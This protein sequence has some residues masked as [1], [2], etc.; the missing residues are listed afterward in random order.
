MMEGLR[1]YRESEALKNADI[2][3]PRDNRHDEYPFNLHFR[4]LRIGTTVKYPGPL[5]GVLDVATA[6]KAGTPLAHI[7]PRRIT[8]RKLA[9]E[10]IE[11]GSAEEDQSGWILTLRSSTTDAAFSGGLPAL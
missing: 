10:R 1:A 11:L 7:P 2:D 3:F 8:R 9:Q 4:G 5:Y 6:L